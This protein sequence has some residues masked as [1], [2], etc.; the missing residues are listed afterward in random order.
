MSVSL[1]LPPSSPSPQ[2]LILIISRPHS[3]HRNAHKHTHKQL[4][5]TE[6][7]VLCSQVFL[8]ILKSRAGQLWVCMTTHTCVVIVCM[9]VCLCFNSLHVQTKKASNKIIKQSSVNEGRIKFHYLNT[10]QGS[11]VPL[12]MSLISL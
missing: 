10:K 3:L 12:D 8:L 11:T 9:G 5:K 6:I 4:T 2:A 7:P 1:P